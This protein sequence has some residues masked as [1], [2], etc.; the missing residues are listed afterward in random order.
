MPCRS[1]AALLAI[2]ALASAAAGG[3]L[4]LVAEPAA[5]C[6]CGIAIEASVSEETG[7]VIA[8]QPGREQIVLSL[9]LAADTE[10][11]RAAV[12][13]P[14]PGEPRVEAIAHGDPLAYLD[15]TTAPAGEVGAAAGSGA[16]AVEVIGREQVGGY[17]VARLRAGDSG[18]L[19]SWLGR[20]GYALPGG[21]E[22]ILADYID[23]R[24]SFV[25]IRLA[26]AT[27]GRLK[28]LEVSFRTDRVVYPMRL[29]QLATDPVSLTL[30]TLAGGERRVAGLETVW[31]GPVSDL[32]PQPPASLSQL[33]GNGGYLTR[34]Q[35]TGV[36]PARF[37]T[38]LV[39][40]PLPGSGAQLSQSERNVVATDE[41]GGISAAGLAALIAAGIAFALG[42]AVLTRPRRS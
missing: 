28:P 23:R 11:G 25:A 20:N 2:A 32:D 6:A 21:A 10:A 38:D 19:D 31:A 8:R 3:E 13:L 39:V 7:L 33:F 5:A 4:R 35:A 42:L 26:P 24:W 36:E 40:E 29:E 16:T 14:V 41:G 15:S 9:D 1:R 18:A 27:E 37:T 22:P 30:Y 12:V 34:M 17:D